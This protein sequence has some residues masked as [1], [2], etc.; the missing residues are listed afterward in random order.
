MCPCGACAPAATVRTKGLIGTARERRPAGIL[1]AGRRDLLVVPP[2]TTP[3]SAA[4]L[5]AAASADTGPPRT[6]TML[7]TAERAD[8]GSRVRPGRTGAAVSSRHT[9]GISDAL[10]GCDGTRNAPP[11]ATGRRRGGSRHT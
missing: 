11:A 2:Q 5:M 4:R 9:A 6:A 3:V 1:L 8:R 7:M 10:P